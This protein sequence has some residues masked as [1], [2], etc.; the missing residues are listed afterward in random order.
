MRKHKYKNKNIMFSAF[1]TMST[2]Q[3]SQS[4]GSYTLKETETDI[5]KIV[6]GTNGISV[7]VQYE[8]LQ[9]SM[10]DIFVGICFDLRQCE[11]TVSLTIIIIIT[12]YFISKHC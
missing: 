3:V 5:D 7:S 12:W 9:N 11:R 8:H 4:Q 10:Q 1:Y 2:V 6:T